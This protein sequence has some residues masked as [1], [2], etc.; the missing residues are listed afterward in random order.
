MLVRVRMRHLLLV[1]AAI[2]PTLRSRSVPPS[3]L[4]RR[5]PIGGR[6][7]LAGR[8]TLLTRVG[9]VAEGR[10]TWRRTRWRTTIAAA[11]VLSLRRSIAIRMP[12]SVLAR[13]SGR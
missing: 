11:P 10:R 4:R 8:R 1:T 12:V 7:V 6:R 2:V 5:S 9:A 13:F 3:V